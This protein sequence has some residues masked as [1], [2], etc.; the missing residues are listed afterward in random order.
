M[1]VKV[2]AFLAEGGDVYNFKQNRS[3]DTVFKA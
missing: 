2:C 3:K 1:I